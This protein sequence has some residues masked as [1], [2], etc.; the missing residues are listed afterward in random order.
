[1]RQG[2]VESFE[3]V[4]STA[5]PYALTLEARIGDTRLTARGALDEPVQLAGVEATLDLQGENLHELFTLVA[6]PLPESPPYAIAGQLTREGDRWALRDFEGRLGK[7][8]L[9]GTLEVATGG[10][11]PRLV[12]DVASNAFRAED[13]EGFWG[14]EDAAGA[15]ADDGH[16]LSDEPLSLPKLRRMDA[17][18]RFSGKSIESGALRLQDL[19]AALRDRKRT[20]LNSSH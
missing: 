2:G 4:R 13:L 17:A 20:S 7:S 15:A 3:K 1:M 16:I 6:L 12:A 14:E 5:E 11:R 8:D 10:E 9:R 18:V 19:S